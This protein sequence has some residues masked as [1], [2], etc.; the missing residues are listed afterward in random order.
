MQRVPV[1]YAPLVE[2]LGEEEAR[3]ILE[4]VM[5]VIAYTHDFGKSSTY[6]QRRVRGEETKGVDKTLSYHVE[7]SMLLGFL[8][9]QELLGS[10]VSEMLSNDLALVAALVIM[11]HHSS[12]LEDQVEQILQDEAIERAAKILADISSHDEGVGRYLQAI[13]SE[14]RV[15]IEPALARLLSMDSDEIQE[16]IDQIGDT[17]DMTAGGVTLFL[18]AEFLYSCVCDADEYDAK[19]HIGDTEDHHFPSDE[20]RTRLSEDLVE[21]YRQQCLE[22]G[23]WNLES[24]P[25][26]LVRLRNSTY[27]EAKGLAEAAG[28]GGLYTLS[29]PTGSGKTLALLDFSVRIRRAVES[30]HGYTPK[31]VYALPFVSIAD[32]VGMQIARV[33]GRNDTNAQD[34]LLTIH[35]HLVEPRWM[36]L[37]SELPEPAERGLSRLFMNLWRSDFVVTS[38]VKLWDSI[39]SGRKR[40]LLRL[41]RIAGSILLLDEVQ[42]LPVKYW[43]VAASVLTA[44]AEDYGCIVVLSTATLPQILDAATVTSAT[45]SLADYELS[46][47]RLEYDD[48]EVDLRQFSSELASHLKSHPSDSVMAVLN[49]KRSAYRVYK[50]LTEVEGMAEGS[51]LFFMSGLVTPADRRRTLE[52]VLSCLETREKRCVLVSTQL[53]EAGV[54]VSFDTVFRDFAPLDSLVQ[55]A[56]RCNRHSE[57]CEERPVFVRNI[58]DDGTSCAMLAYQDPVSLGTTRDVLGRHVRISE[59]EVS[60]LC[61]EYYQLIRGRKETS[62]CL[63]VVEQL[64]FRALSKEFSLIEELKNTV[65]VFVLDERSADVLSR[66]RTMAEGSETAARIPPGFH[67][68]SIHPT[69]S[70][71]PAHCQL[72]PFDHDGETVFYVL[73]RSHVAG[74]YSPESGLKLE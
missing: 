28:A 4:M 65:T 19:F 70:Q 30:T 8:S 10:R 68:H 58:L 49:T 35:H 42:S 23:T 13:P 55:V 17:R 18:L 1:R 57:H 59:R 54:D 22:L 32:Q 53:I 31:V 9:I 24:I 6:F 51:D 60:N 56:G 50:H 46:R 69:R 61:R 3:R 33:L 40:E 64:R 48:S 26:E 71:I 15:S 5:R 11:N 7:V 67:Q 29:A 43:D 27:R 21:A 14:I 72:T 2:E 47:Y 66:L 38:F 45:V 36:G 16:L 34:P 74:A 25:E 37:Q 52:N 39:L 20:K 44:L 63:D 62:T 73:D 41:N 12:L